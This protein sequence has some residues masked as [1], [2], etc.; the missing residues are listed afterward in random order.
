MKIPQI[1]FALTIALTLL[2][3]CST[4][5]AEPA[6]LATDVPG[7]VASSSST[8][9]AEASPTAVPT[10]DT[11]SAQSEEQAVL[12]AFSQPVTATGEAMILYGHVLDSNGQPLSGYTVE[13]WQVDANGNYDH[14]NDPGTQ[15]RDLNFQFYGTSLTDENGLFVFRTIIPARYEPRPRHIHFK[16]KN[17]GAEV[18]TS[19][20]YFS[21]E[22]DASQLGSAGEMLL[23]D[24]SDV[25]DGNGNPVKLAFKDIA[26]NT[27]SVGDMTLTPSQIEGPYYPVV[28]VATFDNDLASVE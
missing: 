16:V 9:E 14:P 23:L 8:V 5:V 20:F 28:D 12:S 25:Q 26:V 11:M 7:T 6:I 10:V 13:I 15:N 22:V 2:T 3:A 17:N 27:G 1:I 19:Q 18:L 4:Q 21:G 24:L